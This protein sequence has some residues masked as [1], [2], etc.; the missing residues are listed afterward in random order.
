MKMMGI[1]LITNRI[2]GKKYVGQSKNIKQRWK[3]HISRERNTMIHNAIKKYGEENFYFKILERCP[4]EKL[5]ERERFYYNKLKPEY[6]AIY[7][8]E[9]PMNYEY[10]RIKQK[11]AVNTEEY[12]KMMSNKSKENF[13]KEKLIKL[14]ESSHTKEAQEKRL[15]T[16]NS[17][18]YKNRA[19]NIHKKLWQNKEYREKVLPLV[20]KNLEETRKKEEVIEK[21]RKTS[22][23]RWENPEYRKHII[24]ETIAKQRK[25]I[26]IYNANEEMIFD[27]TLEASKWFEKKGK[28]QV[29]ARTMISGIINGKGKSVYGYLVELL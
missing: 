21:I 25:K 23:E 26:K 4:E 8:E 6:N 16:Q 14:V 5:T 20:R 3:E 2:N 19:S 1:Y 28:N 10:I 13:T 17:F 9:N 7:P 27:S 29:S 11:E 12:K 22:K 24:E 15:K 18:E